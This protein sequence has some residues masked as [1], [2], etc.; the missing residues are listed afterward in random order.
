NRT[1]AERA[2]SIN[3]SNVLTLGGFVTPPE[4]AKEIVEAWLMTEFASGWDPPIQNFLHR[5][6]GDIQ[7]IEQRLSG[8]ARQGV[9]EAMPDEPP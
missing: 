4:E 3:N 6:M 2:R 1:A 8:A 7:S 9:K 5:S